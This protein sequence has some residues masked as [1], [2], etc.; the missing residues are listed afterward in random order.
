[1]CRSFVPHDQPTRCIYFTASNTIAT[2]SFDDETVETLANILSTDGVAEIKEMRG[3]S[4][5]G[6]LVM[7]I[8]KRN[9]IG[10]QHEEERQDLSTN[11]V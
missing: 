8:K 10:K 6:K 9:L 4:P 3:N 5:L 2:R 1:M 7:E 11:G